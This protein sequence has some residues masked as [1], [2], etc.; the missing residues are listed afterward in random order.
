MEKEKREKQAK[1]VTSLVCV[2]AEEKQ[3]LKYFI[4][5]NKK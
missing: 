1:S 4:L 3:K 5:K 2:C